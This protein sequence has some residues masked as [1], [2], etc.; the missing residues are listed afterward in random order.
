MTQLPSLVNQP[1]ARRCLAF[2]LSMAACLPACDRAARLEALQNRS[3]DATKAEQVPGRSQAA[4]QDASAARG[5][6]DIEPNELQ[7]TGRKQT[8]VSLGS[9]PVVITIHDVQ[10]I[11]AA[12]VRALESSPLEDRDYLLQC[13]KGGWI[14]GD[15]TVRIGPWVLAPRQNSLKLTF[16]MPGLQ[17]APAINTYE[18]ALDRDD[19]WRVVSITRGHILRR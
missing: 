14:D 3:A 11:E 15:G 18:A 13:T 4:K 7:A 9:K 1:M 5:E 19:P 2:G 6:Q 17:T 12:L 10:A 16:R 8:E